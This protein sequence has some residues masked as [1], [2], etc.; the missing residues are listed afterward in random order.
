M[1]NIKLILMGMLAILLTFGMGLTGCSSDSDDSGADGGYVGEEAR[2][3]QELE[4]FGYTIIERERQVA[5]PGEW[6]HYEGNAAVAAAITGDAFLT[7]AHDG[8]SASIYFDPIGAPTKVK[9]IA[10]FINSSLKLIPEDVRPALTASVSHQSNGTELLMISTAEATDVPFTISSDSVTLLDQLFNA[11]AMSGSEWG[12]VFGVLPSAGDLGQRG[13]PYGGIAAKDAYYAFTAAREPEYET[14]DFTVRAYPHSTVGTRLD[15]G[16]L[17]IFDPDGPGIPIP[18]G[19]TKD[20]IA[21]VLIDAYNQYAKQEK[22]EGILSAIPSGSGGNVVRVVN[23]GDGGV[24]WPGIDGTE[25]FDSF[26]YHVYAAHTK[27]GAAPGAKGNLIQSANYENLTEKNLVGARLTV[28]YDGVFDTILFPKTEAAILNTAAALIDSGITTVNT[29]V[30]IEMFKDKVVAGGLDTTQ[31]V[32]YFYNTDPETGLKIPDDIEVFLN[33]SET[34]DG[35]WGRE[36]IDENGTGGIDDEWTVFIFGGEAGSGSTDPRYHHTVDSRIV[37]SSTPAIALADRYTDIDADTSTGTPA[38]GTSV[39]ADA[40]SIAYTLANGRLNGDVFNLKGYNV[41]ED[42]AGNDDSGVTAGFL[43]ASAITGGSTNP[44]G[45]FGYG[46]QF[47]FR[48]VFSAPEVSELEF[49]IR[50]PQA[51]PTE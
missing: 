6:W 18:S 8:L 25:I 14:W 49:E 16:G 47:Y 51:N 5:V 11:G 33:R 20:Q 31:K 24:E 1:K 3:Q 7:L 41:A 19:F 9:D 10:D 43:V 37:I 36:A 34:Y 35:E 32:I 48:K 15:V 22:L 39:L 13:N 30:T 23:K 27:E 21:T 12:T 40:D 45:N 50:N 46:N 28:S 38:V 2:H 26:G 44:V 42:G 4:D 29:G 17:D